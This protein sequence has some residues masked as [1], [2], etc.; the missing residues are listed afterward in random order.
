MEIVDSGR[1]YSSD[2]K[3]G[4]ARRVKEQKNRRGD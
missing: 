3:A 2:E 4:K 1:I